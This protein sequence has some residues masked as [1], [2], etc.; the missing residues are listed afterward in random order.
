MD[1]DMIVKLIKSIPEDKLN[2]DETIK[3]IIDMAAKNTGKTFTEDQ[4]NSFLQQFKA[5]A[6]ERNPSS[7]AS[8]ILY[9]GGTADQLDEIKKK[10]DS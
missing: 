1:I 5:F 2:D 9:R 4:L 10:L 8:K 6:Q 3:A 7:L